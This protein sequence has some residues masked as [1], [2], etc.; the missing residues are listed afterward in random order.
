MQIQV[1]LTSPISNRKVAM[2]G[3]ALYILRKFGI[4]DRSDQESILIDVLQY[5]K[6]SRIRGAMVIEDT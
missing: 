3:E 4:K 6:I 1:T 2:R 5:S